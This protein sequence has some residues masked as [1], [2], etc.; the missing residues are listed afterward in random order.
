[1]K[2]SNLSLHPR[3]CQLRIMD[4]VGEPQAQ[5]RARWQYCRAEDFPGVRAY[6]LPIWHRLQCG[7]LTADLFLV[8]R[9]AVAA[10]YPMLCS[11]AGC[12]KKCV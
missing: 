10:P 9:W 1:M 6:L 8:S 5:C 7:L 12:S 2:K 3:N 11:H 4:A